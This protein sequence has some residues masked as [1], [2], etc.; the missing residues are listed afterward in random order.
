MNANGV[1]LEVFEGPLDLLLHL[2]RKNDL[3]VYDIPIS[4]ITAEYLN[5]LDLMK[6]MNLDLAGEFLV[7]ASTLIQIKAHTLLP[8][9]KTEGEE[10]PDPRAELVNRLLEYQ[11]FKEASRELHKQY[12]S[13]KDIF[14]RGLPVFTDDDFA[15]GTTLFDLMDAFRDVLQ[16]LEPGVR[17]VVYE[18]I[19]LEVKIREILA[20][21]EDKTFVT[22]REILRLATTRHGLVVTF[23]AIL[24]LIRLRQV[25]ARQVELFGEIRVYRTT[26]G[27]EVPEVI[28]E[29]TA[30]AELAPPAAP[31]EAPAAPA[32]DAFD[33]NKI[34]NQN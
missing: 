13:R 32:V 28:E 15:M 30:V 5:Y 18:E 27:A 9:T 10:G 1:K 21:M 14:Y 6:E 33:V 2:I 25:A 17:E 19:P 29:M 16:S 26:E 12:E 7:M 34:L 22:F 31:P 23:L 8:A 11:R 3:N 20:Y 24:E 4:Q